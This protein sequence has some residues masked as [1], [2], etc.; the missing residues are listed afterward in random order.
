MASSRSQTFIYISGDPADNFKEAK[1][2]QDH[3]ITLIWFTLSWNETVMNTINNIQIP[4][5]VWILAAW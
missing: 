2:V 5:D 3:E 4:R 1:F